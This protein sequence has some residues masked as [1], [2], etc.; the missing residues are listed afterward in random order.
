MRNIQAVETRT[1]RMGE[2]VNDY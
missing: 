1:G 2:D